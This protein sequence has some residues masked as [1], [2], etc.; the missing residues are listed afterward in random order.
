[1]VRECEECN[2]QFEVDVTKRNWRHKKLCSLKCQQNRNTRR[3]REQYQKQEWPQFRVCVWCGTEFQIDGPGGKPQKYC[4]RRCYLDCRSEKRAKEVESKLQPKICPECNKPF[5]P[6]KFSG[7]KQMYCSHNCYFRARNKGTVG[8]KNRYANQTEFARARRIALK[9]DNKTCVLC[10]KKG[11]KLNV[12]HSDCS[13]GKE[14]ANNHPDNLMTLCGDCHD[15]IH[16]VCVVPDGEGWAVTG[17]IF[18]I[19]NLAGYIKINP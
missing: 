16:N 11:V 10:G 14:N 4:S 5:M 8:A 13:G 6:S 17:K 15:G 3:I 1:M 19:L 9:R 18:K 7:Q 12:H 2:A